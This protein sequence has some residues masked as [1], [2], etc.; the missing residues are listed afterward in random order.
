LK[1]TVLPTLTHIHTIRR[2]S[3]KRNTIVFL[4][5]CMF[6]ASFAGI[7]LAQNANVAGTWTISNQGRGGVV[8]STLTITGDGAALKG[9]LKGANG[10]EL[11]LDTIT[12]TGN[13]IDFVVTRQGRGGNPVMVE[14]K[15]TVDGSN[16][17]GT[18]KQGDND[19][20]WTATKS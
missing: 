4:A 9:T 20:E 19:V 7:A 8:M 13:A 15:G 17:K 16:M 6:V 11:P 5:I 10:M 3:M 1:L 2:N 18:F 14:Y 12:V